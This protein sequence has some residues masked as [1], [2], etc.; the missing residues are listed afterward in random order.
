[1]KKSK[2]EIIDNCRKSIAE[3][4]AKQDK[5]FDNLKKD[6]EIEA[7]DEYFLDILFDYCYN[8]GE[9]VRKLLREYL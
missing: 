3:L 6:L 4:Q 7:D 9:Y 5:L 8:E 1:M 2:I